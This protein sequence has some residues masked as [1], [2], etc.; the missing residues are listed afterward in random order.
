[1][2]DDVG[3]PHNTIFVTGLPEGTDDD[4]LK[5][6]FEAYGQIKWHRVMRG[7]KIAGLVQYSSIEE[8][9]YVVENL[10]GSILYEGHSPVTIRFANKTGPS[11]GKGGGK[12]PGAQQRSSPYG[13]PAAGGWSGFS[14]GG[15]R[16]GNNGKGGGKGGKA[17]ARELLMDLKSHNKLPGGDA[18]PEPNSEVFVGSLPFDTTNEDV[19]EMFAP[20]GAIPPRG[21]KALTNPDGSCKGVAFVNYLDPLHAQLAIE[22]LHGHPMPNGRTLEVKLKT[23]KAA[24]P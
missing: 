16:P 17:G 20:F 11:A 1:M 2:G 6:A 19:Y 22:T 21:V 3:E 9:T 12:G 24:P 10:N 7:A 14:G 5:G 15:G 13:Q 18:P 8:A 4:T 23:P